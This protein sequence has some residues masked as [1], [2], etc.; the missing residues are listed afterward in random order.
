MVNRHDI[1]TSII[2]KKKIV[3]LP[4]VNKKYT[5]VIFRKQ[6]PQFRGK[7]IKQ[8]KKEKILKKI[9]VLGRL[10]PP[11]TSNLNH[12]QRLSIS[13]IKPIKIINANKNQGKLIK[14]NL[15]KKKIIYHIRALNKTNFCIWTK[16]SINQKLLIITEKAKVFIK[17]FYPIKFFRKSFIMCRNLKKK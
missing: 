17:K 1:N 3:F 9:R 14:N 2:S 4:F 8:V 10:G 11:S 6:L 5:S 7:K 15:F 13:Q 12:S 16:Q